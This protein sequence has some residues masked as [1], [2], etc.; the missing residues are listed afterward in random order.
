MDDTEWKNVHKRTRQLP[1]E[2]EIVQLQEL[3]KDNSE[4]DLIDKLRQIQGDPEP[5]I[6]IWLPTGSFIPKNGRSEEKVTQEFVNANYRNQYLQPIWN[7]IQGIEA[8]GRAKGIR[9]NVTTKKAAQVIRSTPIKLFGKEYQV[10]AN[11]HIRREFKDAFG[12][13]KERHEEAYYIHLYGVDHDIPHW[14]IV[15]ELRAQGLPAM[16]ATYGNIF[17]TKDK[18]YSLAQKKRIVYF[19]T[20]EIPENL[21][22]LDKKQQMPTKVK[23]G[24]KSYIYHHKDQY[25]KKVQ[26]IRKKPSL[27]TKKREQEKRSEKIKKVYKVKQK[28]Q[29]VEDQKKNST[30]EN[31]SMEIEKE[32]GKESSKTVKITDEKDK[33]YATEKKKSEDKR[34]P[35]WITVVTAD[36][37]EAKQ[38]KEKEEESKKGPVRGST[39]ERLIEKRKRDEAYKRRQKQLIKERADKRWNEIKQQMKKGL[40]MTKKELQNTRFQRRE[41]KKEAKKV[42]HNQEKVVPVPPDINKKQ[43]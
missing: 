14:K 31:E 39:L 17:T 6:S 25:L 15:Q 23:I 26:E 7:D 30:K 43:Y 22:K 13:L 33:E 9:I 8:K 20:S 2:V 5:T 36:E 27:N 28:V 37:E 35:S 34:L 4:Q 3:A 40:S 11:L 16:Y 1:T 18:R 10:P 19:E 12:Q 21:K 29:E 38:R 42:R 24:I 41:E 32:E